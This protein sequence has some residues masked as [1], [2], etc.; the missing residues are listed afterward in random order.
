M[1]EKRKARFKLN[2]R[3]DPDLWERFRRFAENHTPR[4]TDTELIERAL[5][6][7]LDR[8]EKKQRR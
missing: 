8:H 3:I 4:A 6:E 5:A 7:F 2:R 1:E